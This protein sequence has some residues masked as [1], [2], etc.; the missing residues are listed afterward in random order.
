MTNREDD[1]LTRML[2]EFW[3]MQEHGI[4]RHERML[5]TVR[6]LCRSYPEISEGRA[7]RLLSDALDHREVERA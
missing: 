4:P 1:Y 3:H 5:A 6:A 2:I 7:Y